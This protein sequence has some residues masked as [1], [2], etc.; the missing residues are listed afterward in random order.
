[1]QFHF[2]LHRFHTHHTYSQTSV[3][4]IADSERPPPAPQRANGYGPRDV[5]RL[6]STTPPLPLLEHWLTLSCCCA[7]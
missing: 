1:M 5:S 6:H 7:Q 3:A 4:N 2:M